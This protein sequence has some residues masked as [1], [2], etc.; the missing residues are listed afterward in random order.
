LLRKIQKKPRNFY[1]TLLQ[2][3]DPAGSDDSCDLLLLPQSALT[4]TSEPLQAS[5][6]VVFG[7]PTSGEFDA[8]EI[9]RIRDATRAS[10][11]VF[12]PD[13]SPP[14][15]QASRFFEALTH[16]EALDTA[17]AIAA[18]VRDGLGSPWIFCERHFLART[19]LHS[20]ALQHARRL[21]HA[22]KLK[23][24]QRIQREVTKSWFGAESAGATRIARE[25]A[26]TSAATVE[27]PRYLQTGVRVRSEDSKY[28]NWRKTRRFRLHTWHLVDAFIDQLADGAISKLS[29]FPDLELPQD[30]EWHK[31]R[32]ALTAVNCAIISDPVLTRPADLKFDGESLSRKIEKKFGTLPSYFADSTTD[33]PSAAGCTIDLPSEGASSFAGFLLMPLTPDPVTA[34]L[35]VIYENRV[36][37]TALL[38]GPVSKKG[39]GTGK[40]RDKI[41]LVPEGIVRASFQDLDERR[42]FDAAFIF[43][44]GASGASQATLIKDGDVKLRDVSGDVPAWTEIGDV[45][46][47][48]TDNPDAFRSIR[49]VALRK[50]L[51]KL[52]LKGVKIR[53]HFV[54]DSGLDDSAESP[55][56]RIQI[57]SARPEA[58]PPLEF[59]Y[60]GYA[61]DE[62]DAKLCPNH[63]IA[64]K[65][66]ACGNCPHQRG[67]EYVCALRFWGM[68]KVIE[69]HQYRPTLPEGDYVRLNE[70]IGEHA[71]PRPAHALFAWSKRATNFT[72]GAD[73]LAEL[74]NRLRIVATN[75]SA[76]KTWKRWRD[77]V[78]NKRPSLLLMLAHTDWEGGNA[79][80]EIAAK[81]RLVDSRIDKR[82][83]G[84]EDPASI[85]VVLGCST[86]DRSR[87][88]TSL[89]SSFRRAG[90]KIV[91]ATLTDV[92]GRHAAPA[93]QELLSGLD[94][95]WA[96]KEKARALG[97]IL[98]RLRRRLISRGLPIG[99]ALVAYGDAD[100]RIE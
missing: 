51:V 34:R 30:E 61:P 9:V 92:L 22:G 63:K 44:H 75:A 49:S 33:A 37:Q 94:K 48:A 58:S 41:R 25:I 59:V 13:S 50:L 79:V 95:C 16:N 89:P 32:V 67:A 24:A 11:V 5:A 36:L 65:N 53:G 70:T 99:M 57:I 47:E 1:K 21:A 72:G 52:A 28:Q 19:R 60:D 38:R 42:H 27:K 4:S 83:V 62:D 68:S 23:H 6:V 15:R 97:D 76:V 84:E 81:E 98:T 91:V 17:A 54:E 45:L 78:K 64:M 43:N 3:V 39:G 90:A 56:R 55:I 66:G 8:D 86:A 12:L 7:L 87:G 85:V 31:L 82:I 20:V 96:S 73:A 29:P 40:S 2:F 77:E 46:V 93:A 69:R 88:Y 100:R 14:D 18:G 80:L 35:S 10:A 71:I 74:Q 26:R